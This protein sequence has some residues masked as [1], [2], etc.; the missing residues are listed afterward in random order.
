VANAPFA[1]HFSS[2]S[3]DYARF[4]PDYPDA[5]FDWLAKTVRRRDLAWDCATGNGQAAV[6]LAGRFEE[7]LAT[8]GSAA[9]LRAATRNPRVGYACAVAGHA[10]L[11]DHA[12]DLVTVAQA[13]HWFDLGAFYGEVAR[14]ARGDAVIAVWSY[15]HTT[16]DPKIDAVIGSFYRD[17]IG[18]YWPAGRKHVENGYRDL[19]FPFARIDAPRFEMSRRWSLGELLGY[20]GTWSAVK[21]YREAVGDAGIVEFAEKLARAWGEASK[22]REVRWPLTLRVGRINGS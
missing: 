13:L 1:D 3:S 6:G 14:V 7:V 4:R 8:D 15:G 22:R 16:V 21:R 11:G 18:K 17:T 10:P 2:G 9:Q 19:A 12:V 5:L 20:V